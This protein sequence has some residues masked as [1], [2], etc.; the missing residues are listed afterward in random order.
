MGFFSSIKKSFKKVF[1]FAKKAAPI[2]LAAGAVIFT[3]GAALGLAPLG[4]AGGWGAAATA[5]SSS[6]GLTGAVGSVVSGAIT[7]AGFGALTGGAISALSGGSFTDGAQMGALTGAAGGGILGGF[8]IGADPFASA[9]A[10]STTGGVTAG[11][12]ANA[13]TGNV[14]GPAGNAATNASLGGVPNYAGG[15]SSAP[16]PSLGSAPAAGSSL[17]TGAGGGGSLGSSAG[18]TLAGGGGGGGGTGIGTWL[19]DT[20]G[21]KEVLGKT[22]SGVGQGM[23]TGLATE[24]EADALMARDRRT[25]DNYR[26]DPS[27]YDVPGAQR[28]P[29]GGGRNRRVAYRYEYSPEE[30]R[31]VRRAQEDDDEPRPRR[32]RRT[33]TG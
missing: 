30:K 6:L 28:R 11:E 3:G 2:A 5:F 7:G 22:L 18:S 14:S 21:S 23:A 1:S 10:D 4:I 15:A 25:T 19:K 13:F 31:V 16:L 9:F 17:S 32:G 26:I 27:V 20:V 8:G 12:A 29:D 24:S 33:M